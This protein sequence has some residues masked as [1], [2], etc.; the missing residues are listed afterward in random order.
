MIR[1]SIGAAV[2]F[3]LALFVNGHA[4]A[5]TP[6]PTPSPTP[7]QGFSAIGTLTLQ[8]E[9]PGAP[10]NFA[11][12]IAVMSKARRI[13]LDVLHAKVV[14]SAPAGSTTMA[15]V[16][17][18]GTITLVF[19]QRSQTFTIWSEQKRVYYQM[20]MHTF[21]GRKAV[22]NPKAAPTPSASPIDQLL[23]ATKTITE[24]DVF[25]ESLALVGHQHVN[26]HAASLFHFT[27]QSQKHGDKPA[28]I[29]GDLALADDLS[30]IPV[31]LWIAV[32]APV[33]A[34]LK[35]DLLSAT[36]T[37]PTDSAFA[38]PV[39]YKKVDHILK[40]LANTSP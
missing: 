28:D 12:E 40:V 27:F 38:V 29:S 25:N 37:P 24:Y 22:P 2:A 32:K 36:T 11:A 1:F 35:L 16:L 4:L 34:D 14:G 39:G 15:Q 17:P 23:R 33:A 18:R 13:R 20:K 30:G 3:V 8:A 26:G 9:V 7:L 31:R 19:D 21:P 6:A 5:Q 10:M